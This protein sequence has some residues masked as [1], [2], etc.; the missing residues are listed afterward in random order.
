LKFEFYSSETGKEEEKL[1]G[2]RKKKNEGVGGPD[3]TPVTNKKDSS[4][5]KKRRGR[6][7]RSLRV[8]VGR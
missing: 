2:R 6:I 8:G 7:V 1:K 4:G 5:G 3:F